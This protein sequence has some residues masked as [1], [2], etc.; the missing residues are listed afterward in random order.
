MAR[1]DTLPHFLT[2][3]ADA[4]RTK[5]GTSG[6]IV[7][8]DFDTEISNLPSG[9]SFDITDG[10]YL[11]YMGTRT[12]NINDLT[13]LLK[14]TTATTHMFRNCSTITSVPLFDT[15][16]VTDAQNMFDGCRGLTSLPQFNFEKVYRGDYMF[17]YC[18]SLTSIPQFNFSEVAFTSSMFD[19]CTNLVDFPIT[20]MPKMAYCGSMFRDCTSL[21]NDSL[22]NILLMCANS[23]VSNTYFKKL[24]TLGLTS[25]QATT[26]QSLSNYQAFL[27][28]G[29]T[30]GY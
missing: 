28:A 25:A 23:S 5:K 30:T 14:N 29:W 2:D 17:E 9:A 11:F 21:S 24:S 16:K 4:I 26:C 3:V 22:N 20:S 8:S 15:S 13:S 1:T 19:G 7:A 27:N 6:A 10:S 12:S 18:S